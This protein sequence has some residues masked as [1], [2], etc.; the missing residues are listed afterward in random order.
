MRVAFEYDLNDLVDANVR[1][2]TATPA[3]RRRLLTTR[4]LSAVIFGTLAGFLSGALLHGPPDARA[5]FGLSVTAVV[6]A[7]QWAT[8]M[9]QLRDGWRRNLRAMLGS[10]G[11]FTCEVELRPDGV[12]ARQSHT[13]YLYE[14]P[15][16][17]SIEDTDG[18]INFR[19]RT[20]GFLVVRDRAFWSPDERAKFL[21]TAR[22]YQAMYAGAGE[23]PPGSLS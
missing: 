6:G 2:N 18:S 20:G 12:W 8:Y 4:I 15:S 9:V 5:A 16:V 13:Q 17:V 1:A 19:T 11:P 3:A 14:W 7:I 21:V 10:E 22:Q 23:M